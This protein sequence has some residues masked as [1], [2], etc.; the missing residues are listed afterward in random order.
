M[1]LHQSGPGYTYGTTIVQLECFLYR[2]VVQ[3]VKNLVDDSMN[4][5]FD[6]GTTGRRLQT[7]RSETMV[8]RNPVFRANE[9]ETMGFFVLT[10]LMPP[11]ITKNNGKERVPISS[12]L[13]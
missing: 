4:E 10:N 12:S 5:R 2:D 1:I 11:Q 7:I 9:F 3:S 6:N 13:K 8:A